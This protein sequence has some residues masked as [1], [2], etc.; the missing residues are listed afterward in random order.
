MKLRFAPT[1][2]V[3]TVLALLM[4][5]SGCKENTEGC[6]NPEAIN[7]NPDATDD[8]GSCKFPVAGCMDATADNYNP[9][10][11]DDD[12]SCNYSGCTDPTADNYNPQAN[13]DDGSCVWYGCTNPTADNYDPN[14]TM[15]DGSCIDQRQKFVGSY[16]NQTDCTWPFDIGPTPSFAMDGS[17][18]SDTI[19]ISDFSAGGDDAIAIISGLTITVPEQS[20]GALLERT[21]DGSG[22]IDTTTNVVTIDFNYSVPFLGS[23]SCSGTYT[24]Q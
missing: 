20:F 6:T 15:D 5:T 12:G 23:G 19:L 14:A 17:A 11:T 16:S 7:Y 24:Q 21:F 1:A 13:I 8:D 18:T 9:N 22:S 3:L 2:A 10:A 4:V